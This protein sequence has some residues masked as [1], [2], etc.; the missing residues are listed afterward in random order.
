MP[1]ERLA[2]PTSSRQWAL[3]EAALDKARRSNRPLVIDRL[4]CTAQDPQDAAAADCLLGDPTL[5][6]AL[7]IQ[8]RIVAPTPWGSLLMSEI[9]ATVGGDS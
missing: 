4:P 5:L 7:T 9:S 8:V 6:S 3:L 1:E 2:D